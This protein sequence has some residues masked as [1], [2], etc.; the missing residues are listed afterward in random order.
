MLSLILFWLFFGLALFQA[1]QRQFLR[2]KPPEDWL[3]DS[4]GLCVQ[5]GLIPLMQIVLQL[6]IYQWLCPQTQGCLNL[7]P[8]VG[9][10][11]SFVGVDYLYYWHHRLLHQKLLFPIHALHHTVTQMDMVGSARNTLWSSFFLPYVWVNSIMVFLLEDPRGYALG[12]FLTYFL[13]L[14]R[15]SSLELPQDS[16]FYRLLNPWLILP[17]DHAYHHSQ[18]QAANF[19]A[20]LKLW[21]IL[22]GTYVKSECNSNVLGI[23]LDMSVTRKLF[24]P[25]PS[26]LTIKH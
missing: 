8:W 3:L 2:A 23:P 12:I 26:P 6:Q 7:S 9:L 5:G 25:F 20:N 17:Q 11:I 4:L 22:H 16:I 18:H 24:W 1:K 15:H 13:D 19:A 14:W 21:D 10:L